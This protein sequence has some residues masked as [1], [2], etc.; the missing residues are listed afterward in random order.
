MDHHCYWM[1]NCIGYNNYRTFLLT[2]L[3]LVMGCWYGVFLLLI[4]FWKRVANDSVSMVWMPCFSMLL[5][6]QLQQDILLQ[7]VL[8]I[9]ICAGVFLSIL[10]GSH[11]RFVASGITTI[12]RAQM[13]RIEREWILHPKVGCEKRNIRFRNIFDQGFRNNLKQI[14]GENPF[15]NA[16]IPISI[17]APLP[18]LPTTTLQRKRQ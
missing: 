16:L 9:L 4:P 1:N 8:Y 14:L 12:E 11:I 7:S 2:I 13:I 17:P 6:G 3:F 10:L 18:F 15:F 5:Q